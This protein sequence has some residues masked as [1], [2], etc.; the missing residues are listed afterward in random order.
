VKGLSASTP[1]RP[2]PSTAV[3]V[4]F[5]TSG[6]DV[7]K[8]QPTH[9]P[10]LRHPENRGRRAAC[11]YNIAIEERQVPNTALGQPSDLVQRAVTPSVEQAGGHRGHQHVTIIGDLKGGDLL[12]RNF[13]QELGL[14]ATHAVKA[15]RKSGADDQ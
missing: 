6:V 13:G 15:R 1:N 8:L 14:I 12:S 11:R 4:R 3:A 9:E 7:G 2:A 5:E 10:A